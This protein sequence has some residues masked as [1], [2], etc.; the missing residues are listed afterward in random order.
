MSNNLAQNTGSFARFLVGLDPFVS[1]RY[2]SSTWPLL[3]N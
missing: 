1:D 2:R 3:L